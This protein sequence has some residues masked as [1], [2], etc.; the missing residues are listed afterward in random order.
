MILIQVIGAF[1]A[2]ISIA[3]TFGVPKKFLGYSGVVGA[4]GWLVF[5]ILTKL[6]C[7]IVASMFVAALVVSLISHSFARI[8]KTPVTLFLIAGILP[9]V[10][11]VGMYRIVYSLLTNNNTTAAFYFSETMQIAGM[12][13]LAIFIMDTL[14]RLFQ[15]K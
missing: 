14:F 2:V 11:G 3:I 9:L 15:K 5:L 6:N 10:P 12:I 8:M 7:T 4:V 13:A 1:V